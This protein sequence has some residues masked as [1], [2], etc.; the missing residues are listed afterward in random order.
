[1]AETNP[2][3]SVS[4]PDSGRHS[5]KRKARKRRAGDSAG[6]LSDGSFDAKAAQW[7]S[8]IL[9]V[10]LL[11]GQVVATRLL[12]PTEMTRTFVIV[13][14]ITL[15]SGLV[16]WLDLLRS[17]KRNPRPRWMRGV[18]IAGF[19]CFSVALGSLIVLT[20]SANPIEESSFSGSDN[21]GAYSARSH[22]EEKTLQLKFAI[23][24]ILAAVAGLSLLAQV[25][26]AN[27]H[28]RS[29]NG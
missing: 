15:L 22:F 27:S 9:G 18:L 23:V 2:P 1:M 25:F 6:A 10:G 14:S 5:R 21:A 29:R 4:A 26:A 3:E 17:K 16:I 19:L 20:M 11:V 8:G 13:L 24:H 28:R 7:I 12:M